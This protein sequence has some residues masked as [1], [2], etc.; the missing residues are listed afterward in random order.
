MPR[1]TKQQHSDII[2]RYSKGELCTHLAREY[3]VDRTS[4]DQLLRRKNVTMHSKSYVY[5]KMSGGELN[6]NCFDVLNSNS[7]YWLGFLMAD[8]S[9]CG[10]AIALVLHSKDRGHLLKFKKFVGGNQKVIDLAVQPGSR[11]AFC[12]IELVKKL[13]SLGIAENKSHSATASDCCAQSKDFWRGVVDGDGYLSN[14]NSKA[15]RFE[16]C[17]SLKMMS[18]FQTYIKTVLNVEINVSTMR[19]IY[20]VQLSGVKACKV[21]DHLYKDAEIFLDRK[22]ELADHNGSRGIFIKALVDSPDLRKKVASVSFG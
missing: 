15:I 18:Q 9:V 5:R 4:I 3:Q 8:G 12:S 13:A 20:R 7:L 1:L 14:I 17:G 22:K 16:L 6:E 19:T 21:I 10:S 11:Y 2:D